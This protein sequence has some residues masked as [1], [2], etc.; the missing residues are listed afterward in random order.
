MHRHRML[1][2][3]LP[4]TRPVMRRM[5]EM[6]SMNDDRLL[7][8]PHYLD[9]RSVLTRTRTIYTATKERCISVRRGA[10]RKTCSA[11]HVLNRIGCFRRIRTINRWIIT[12]DGNHT[13]YL[14]S[15]KMH[16]NDTCERATQVSI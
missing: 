2:M 9:R 8:L 14:Q 16:T 4:M 12:K 11:V 7:P 15:H 13:Q 3:R 10:L 6:H 1:P 5:M